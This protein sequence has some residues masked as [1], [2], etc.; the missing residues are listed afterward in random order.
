MADTKAGLS[1]LNVLTRHLTSAAVHVY[2]ETAS[3]T[4]PDAS[5]LEKFLVRDNAELRNRIYDFLKVLAL[6]VL[7]LLS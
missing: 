1:R 4:L 7:N 2:S 5:D 3:V 6:V